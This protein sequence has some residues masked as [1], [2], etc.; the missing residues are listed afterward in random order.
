V[1]PTGLSRA[2]SGPITSSEL[3]PRGRWDQLVTTGGTYRPPTVLD[4]EKIRAT[5][6]VVGPMGPFCYLPQPPPSAAP[7]CSASVSRLRQPSPSA[8]SVSRPRLLRPISPRPFRSQQQASVLRATPRQ[9]LF[10]GW[11][12]SLTPQRATPES[13]RVY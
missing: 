3:L 13:P 1:V 6:R 8:V 12:N 9:P 7:V 11:S 4:A 10:V 5:A 2:A